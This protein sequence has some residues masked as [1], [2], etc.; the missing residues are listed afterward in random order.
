MIRRQSV[1]ILYVSKEVKYKNMNKEKEIFD[2]CKG[3]SVVLTGK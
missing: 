1:H 3:A 2:N